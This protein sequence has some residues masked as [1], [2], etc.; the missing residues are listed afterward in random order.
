LEPYESLNDLYIP[1]TS[2]K[3]VYGQIIADAKEAA[4]VLPDKAFYD[5]GGRLTQSVANTLLANVYL[6]ISGFPVQ[7]NHYADAASAAKAVIAS[8][9]HGLTTNDD[10]AENSAFNKLRITD[11]LKEVIFAREFNSAVSSSSWWPTY[12]VPNAAAGWSIW[13]YA[14]TNNVYGAVHGFTNVYDPAEDLRVQPNQF[15]HWEY[16]MPDGTVQDLKATC[17]WYYYD[18]EAMLSSGR[19]TKDWNIYRYAEVVLIAA[20]A[21]AKTDGVAAAVGYLAEVKAR[22]SLTGKTKADFENQLS[23]LS[24]DA[25]VQ[26]VWAE[27]LRELPLEFKLWDDII[28][29]HQYPQFSDSKKGSVSFINVVGASNNWGKTF[30]EKDLLWP[31]STNELQRNPQ[32]TQNPGYN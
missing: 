8:G 20:E 31:L 6:Q 11:G 25:F 26:E 13:K 24:V 9:V 30:E 7:E 29:T 14:I 22:A 2:S 16:T 23:S 27:K 1:R 28:R 5:N 3:E 21:V 15:F 17:N 18:E 32:L 4:S 10:L 19:G 12:S